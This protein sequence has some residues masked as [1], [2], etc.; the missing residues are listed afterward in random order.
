M[1]VVPRTTGHQPSFWQLDG[2]GD[3]EVDEEE[4]REGE[5]EEAGRVYC[6]FCNLLS[7]PKLVEPVSFDSIDYARTMKSKL[8][9]I[10]TSCEVKGRDIGACFNC[11]D[12]AYFNRDQ[13]DRTCRPRMNALLAE[14]ELRLK[15]SHSTLVTQQF[16][17][18]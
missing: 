4:E 15:C 5:R 2:Q 18:Y 8:S 17:A 3:S 10:C 16:E 7:K 11:Q 12:I 9:I 13:W 1:K 14:E 6:I